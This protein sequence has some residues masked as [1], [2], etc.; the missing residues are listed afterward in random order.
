MGTP[1]SRLCTVDRNGGAN[2]FSRWSE[3]VGFA[4]CSLDCNSL[5]SSST[6]KI[7]SSGLSKG[8]LSSD[9]R[10]K[11]RVLERPSMEHSN[12]LKGKVRAWSVWVTTS[13][14]RCTFLAPRLMMM[15]SNAPPT[16]LEAKTFEE[17]AAA[18]ALDERIHFSRETGAW[19]YEDEDGTEME[20]D[21]AKK[22]WV[23]VVKLSDSSA[24]LSY[25]YSLNN[26]LMKIY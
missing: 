1:A 3:V 20:W 11:L 8:R 25:L 18:F 15:S 6:A 4:G 14:I 22:A 24:L 9:S 5:L 17:H 7:T 26:S 16:A 10:C 21:T 19:M 13:R 12:G 23:P 2:P